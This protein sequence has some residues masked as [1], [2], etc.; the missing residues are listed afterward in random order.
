MAHA[1]SRLAVGLQSE[2]CLEKKQ[3]ENNNKSPTERLFLSLKS[4]RLAR[5]FGCGQNKGLQTTPNWW[6]TTHWCHSLVMTH[7]LFLFFLSLSKPRAV[8]VTCCQAA[9]VTTGAPVST[10][11]IYTTVPGTAVCAFL[12]LCVFVCVCVCVFEGTLR[13]LFRPRTPT[14]QQLRLGPWSWAGRHRDRDRKETPRSPRWLHHIFGH[15]NGHHSKKRRG[16]R[17]KGVA[18][19]WFGP[20]L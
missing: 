17:K 18:L 4:I 2:A 5:R 8:E 3:K 19:L 20:A 6:E 11:S 1:V 16:K 12:P 15:W 7:F 14:S 13:D 10:S 9:K